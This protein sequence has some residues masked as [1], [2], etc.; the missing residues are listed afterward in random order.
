VTVGPVVVTVRPAVAKCEPDVAVTVTVNV[1][2]DA[3][4]LVAAETVKVALPPAV[5]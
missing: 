3:S 5:T 4:A 1:D 2:V